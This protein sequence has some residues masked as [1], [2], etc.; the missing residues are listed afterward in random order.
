M[1]R[2]MIAVLALVFNMFL[3][4]CTTDSVAET[5][6]LYEIQATEGDDGDVNEGRDD[7]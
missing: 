1:K 6:E 2:I 5:D 4:S 7:D 3:F